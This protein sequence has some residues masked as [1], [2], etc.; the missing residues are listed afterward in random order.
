MNRTELPDI[1]GV[2]E[3]G[4]S[5][6]RYVYGMPISAKLRDDLR[7]KAKSLVPSPADR[8]ALREFQMS[9]LPGCVWFL[10]AA[11]DVI[12]KLQEEVVRLGGT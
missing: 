2:T 6:M 4:P 8:A 7:A 9:P 1:P 3:R 5:G 12:E 11:A 10:R